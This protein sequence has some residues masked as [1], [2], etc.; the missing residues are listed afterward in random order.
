[1][2]PGGTLRREILLVLLATLVAAALGSLFGYAVLAGAAVLLLYLVWQQVALY[3]L[4]RWIERGRDGTPPSNRLVWRDV[5]QAIARLE[6]NNRKRKRKLERLL[7]GFRDSMSALPDATIVLG[8]EL[9]VE[10][11][12]PLAEALFGLR[13]PLDRDR[14][15]Q[16]LIGS[17]AFLD[18]LGS[19]DY[20]QPIEMPAPQR[21]DLLL[22]VRIVPYARGRRLLQ[23]RDIT[24]LRHLEQVRRDFVMN[25]S[26]ELRTPLTVVLGYLEAMEESPEIRG[27]SWYP[28]IKQ[29]SKQTARMRGI[30]E[31]ML[32][33]STLESGRG[34]AED[35][36]VDVAAL[37][38]E[39]REE[40]GVLSG[41]KGHQLVLDAEPGYCLRG[42]PEQIRSVFSNLVSNAVRYTPRGGR[43]H[44]RWWV[45]ARGAHFSV[46]DNGV[47]ISRED[48]PRLT[49]RFYRVD[50]ARSR[51]S[52]GTGLGLAIVKH[53]LVALRGE[54]EIDSTPG[55]GSSF[56]CHFPY[57]YVLTEA[58]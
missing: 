19:G 26:H 38:G 3:R 33:L 11:W 56:T 24:Q 16:D 37:L 18:Y 25:A 12:N 9:E 53:A 8:K 46:S 20:A 48:L 17:P 2:S 32:T 27:G 58:A 1:M 40:A 21:P 7:Y 5:S 31:D 14:K 28:A 55:V 23:A 45:D 35:E 43:I 10:W 15:F 13:F 41:D 29:M 54:L 51:E 22:S 49:E 50:K 39:V 30:V 42:D 4:L 34:D 52:G 44:M 57:G 6:R 47:G 36:L